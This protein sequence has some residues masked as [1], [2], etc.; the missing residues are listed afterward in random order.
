MNTQQLNPRHTGSKAQVSPRPHR[1][2]GDEGIWV[3]I[4]GDLL[5]FTVC[6]AVYLYYRS[7]DTVQFAVSQQGLDLS[8][9]GVNTFLLLTSSVLVVVA[10][11]EVHR[12]SLRA[13]RIPLVGAIFCGLGFIVIKSIEYGHKVAQGITPKTDS[14][15]MYYFVLTGIHLFHVI[16]GLSLLTGMLISAHR[17]R[18]LTTRQER[19][20]ESAG[21]FWHMVDLLW[22]IL[23]PLLYLIG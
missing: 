10:V 12:G 8:Y 23:F 9:G 14:F 17:K 4:F 19:S 15:Y 20:F 5:L 1:T 11:S 13:A 6:F 3:L 7:R 16:I 2:P 18:S 21:I 22:I